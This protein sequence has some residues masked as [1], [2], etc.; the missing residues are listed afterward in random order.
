MLRSA[1][2]DQLQ[3]KFSESRATTSGI[4]QHHIYTI[5]I[6]YSD[7]CYRNC[8]NDDNR[9]RFLIELFEWY[10]TQWKLRFLNSWRYGSVSTVSPKWPQILAMRFVT[11]YFSRG[12]RPPIL[13]SL[14]SLATS[15]CLC[16]HRR[17]EEKGRW[18]TWAGVHIASRHSLFNT[19]PFAVWSV[20]S[21]QVYIRT[22]GTLLLCLL[23]TYNTLTLDE[24]Q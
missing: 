9:L 16:Y 5:T 21:I 1:A 14:S 10:G 3:G 18:R 12:W 23:A 24:L 22:T 19:N 13:L 8:Y 15:K 11:G 20:L 4:V 2:A 17:E 6:L 7:S